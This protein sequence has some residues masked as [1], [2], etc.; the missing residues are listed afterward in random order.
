LLHKDERKAGKSRKNRKTQE[1]G[2]GRREKGEG[3]RQLFVVLS[4]FSCSP[5]LS[6]WDR[7]VTE[8]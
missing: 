3:R 2:E 6:W 5:V 1:K 4:L 8:G 7:S